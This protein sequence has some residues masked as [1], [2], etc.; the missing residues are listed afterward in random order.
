MSRACPCGRVRRYCVFR[1]VG[2]GYRYLELGFAGVQ[3][4]LSCSLLHSNST[5]VSAIIA[6]T[7]INSSGLCLSVM[8]SRGEDC[9]MSHLRS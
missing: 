5:L 6:E 3:C 9:P 4:K 1:A 8:S 7:V 2:K